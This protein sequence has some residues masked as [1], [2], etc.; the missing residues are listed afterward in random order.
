VH[1]IDHRTAEIFLFTFIEDAPYRTTIRGGA[2]SAASKKTE[3]GKIL[4]FAFGAREGVSGEGQGL[5]RKTE[6]KWSTN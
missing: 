3:N 5:E 2:A 6:T 1:R 4:R